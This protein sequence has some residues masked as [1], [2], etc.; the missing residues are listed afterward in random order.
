MATVVP[1]R[2]ATEKVISDEEY[3]QESDQQ[4]PLPLGKPI[5]EKKFWFQRMTKDY[6]PYAIATLVRT[7]FPTSETELNCSLSNSAE[8]V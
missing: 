1:D 2:I 7:L 3:G 5:A 6:D 4:I 8:C